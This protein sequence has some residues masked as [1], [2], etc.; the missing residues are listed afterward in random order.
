MEHV[1][2]T[3]ESSLPRIICLEDPSH[4]IMRGCSVLKEGAHRGHHTS[5]NCRPSCVVRRAG[6]Y[7]KNRTAG[8][9]C[10]WGAIRVEGALPV[11][12]KDHLWKPHDLSQTDPLLSDALDYHPRH[13]GSDRKHQHLGAMRQITNSAMELQPHGLTHMP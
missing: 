7:P 9:L 2:C 1:M 4:S 12:A 8:L 11:G 5:S 3:H 6:A 10:Q 13:L